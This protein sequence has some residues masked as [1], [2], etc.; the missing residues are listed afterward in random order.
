M[1]LGYYT[2]AIKEKP[3]KG[4]LIYEDEDNWFHV[5]DDPENR[6]FFSIGDVEIAFHI[7]LTILKVTEAIKRTKH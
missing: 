7:T 3:D 2:Y 6:V 4:V 1:I 5:I